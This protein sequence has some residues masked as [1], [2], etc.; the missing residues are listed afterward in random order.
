LE[1]G[2]GKAGY[3]RLT[4]Y[5][6]T[7]RHLKVLLAI[8]GWNEGS[9]NY[10]ELAGHPER[11][12]RFVQQSSEFIRRHNFDG[13]SDFWGFFCQRSIFHF[14]GL[15]LDWEY[16]TQRGGLP[17]DKETFVLLV[18]ELS[19]EFKKHNLHLSSAFGAAKK[20]I[21]S[22]Y[23]VARLAPYL[24]TMHIMCYDYFGAW[25]KQIGFNAPLSEDSKNQRVRELTVEYSIKYF[26]DLGAPAEKL[27]MGLP[28]Y[29]R[30]F[31]TKREGLVGDEADDQGFQ[32]PYTRE[33][34]F[35]GYNE[36]RR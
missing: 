13:E 22:A 14:S 19:R 28:F 34:G 16:P 11:R 26:L 32:G 9:Q 29:G 36:V 21:D 20:T 17:Q 30:T 7:H 27:I 23:S 10:S 35:M 12:Q 4:D 31:I 24:D 25:D 33:N 2:G 6:K 1:D 8:G 15:D 18:Q 5:K 3:K